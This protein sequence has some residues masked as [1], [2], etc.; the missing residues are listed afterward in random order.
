MGDVAMTVPVIRALTKQYPACKITV[1][2]KP[3]LRPLFDEMPQVSFFEAQVNTKHKGIIGL[4]KLYRELKKEKITHIAD[5]HNVLRSK[6]L[7]TLF[8][9]SGKWCPHTGMAPPVGTNA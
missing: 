2:S 8:F 3:F 9:L 1:L 7:R 6:I 5:F 4:Y